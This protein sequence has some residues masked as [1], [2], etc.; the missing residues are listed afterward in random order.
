SE[1]ADE[2]VDQRSKLLVL[3]VH[4][5]S[6]RARAERVPPARYPVGRKGRGAR[7]AEDRGRAAGGGTAAVARSGVFARRRSDPRRLL[8]AAEHLFV[9]AQSRGPD[10]VP[11]VPSRAGLART[12]GGIADCAAAAPSN[13]GSAADR[14]RQKVARIAPAE[15]LT[16][17]GE[18][19]ALRD[20]GPSAA[21]AAQ[22][23]ATLMWLKA[24]G[25]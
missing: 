14:A 4:D 18:D 6:R 8:P 21:G 10:D 2:P 24:A 15:I 22:L 9:R 25:R 11:E 12:D 23:C 5:L 1:C 19:R 16:R 13:R 20:P 17:R 3:P 7:A